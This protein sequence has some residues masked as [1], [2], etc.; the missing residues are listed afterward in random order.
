LLPGG[1][2]WPPR[3]PDEEADAEWM[4]RVFKKEGSLTKR[5]ADRV[6]HF[7]LGNGIYAV[8]EP[9]RSGGKSGWKIVATTK[10]RR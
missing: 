9:V 6:K 3:P 7:Y 1:V 5:N 8:A 10:R 4:D 2:S